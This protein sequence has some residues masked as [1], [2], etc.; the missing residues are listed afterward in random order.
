MN[1]MAAFQA[2]GTK[3]PGREGYWYQLEF[4][5]NDTI[6]NLLDRKE[7]CTGYYLVDGGLLE[8]MVTDNSKSSFRWTGH[9]IMRSHRL[10][11][12]ETEAAVEMMVVRHLSHVMRRSRFSR[13][14]LTA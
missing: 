2:D 5:Q 6:T 10:M 8:K 4:H 12:A 1:K 3:E 11:E 9:L 13:L 7:S 14:R